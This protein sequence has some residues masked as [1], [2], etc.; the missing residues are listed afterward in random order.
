[1]RGKESVY[2]GL[3]YGGCGGGAA[4]TAEEWGMVALKDGRVG[5]IKNTSRGQSEMTY[6]RIAAGDFLPHERIPVCG[7][8]ERECELVP[9]SEI[10]HLL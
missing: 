6:K 1:M 5:W 2:I 9:P 7:I 8:S 3:G 4:E 10:D